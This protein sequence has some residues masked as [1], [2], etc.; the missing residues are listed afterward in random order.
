MPADFGM[1]RIFPVVSVPAWAVLPPPGL[2]FGRN[3]NSPFPERLPENHSTE[4]SCKLISFAL[5]FFYIVI[6]KKKACNHAR[7][8]V[9]G[10][11]NYSFSMQQPNQ[12]ES[13]TLSN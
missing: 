3:R 9:T 8:M 1:R 2:T 10:L 7:F 11:T 12:S 13:D 5:S 4:L 6:L